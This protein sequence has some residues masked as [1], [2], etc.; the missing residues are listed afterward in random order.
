MSE[1]LQLHQR[2]V[3]AAYHSFSETCLFNVATGTSVANLSADIGNIAHL[4][5]NGF[6]PS[7]KR[8]GRKHSFT[9]LTFFISGLRT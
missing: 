5:A 4:S 1:R 3:L 8:P 7:S 2:L 6:H 9:T